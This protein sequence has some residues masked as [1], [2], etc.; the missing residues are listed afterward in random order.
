VTEQLVFKRLVKEKDIE[1]EI[2]FN[3]PFDILNTNSS[4][5]TFIQSG[6]TKDDAI[7]SQVLN[8]YYYFLKNSCKE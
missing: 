8:Y 4:P 5:V 3:F 6:G 1:C 2:K 7:L